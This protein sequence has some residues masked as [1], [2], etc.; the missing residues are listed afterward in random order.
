MIFSSIRIF[1]T[2][3]KMATNDEGM[4]D[5]PA[6]PAAGSEDSDR[7]EDHRGAKGSADHLRRSD[8]E[9]GQE[10]YRVSESDQGKDHHGAKGSANRSR[11]DDAE[12][13]R[14]GYRGSGDLN[15][16]EEHCDK[17]STDR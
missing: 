13:G 16:G 11:H 12:P 5:Q 9:P 17:G 1:G 10:D 7:R 14:E 15:R 3:S 2:S 8:A 4:M 6:D